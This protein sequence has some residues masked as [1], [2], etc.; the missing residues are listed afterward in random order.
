MSKLLDATLPGPTPPEASRELAVVPLASGDRFANRYD[1]EA[2]VGRGGM[3]TVWRV[4][5]SL[6][7]GE[8]VALK[9]LDHTSEATIE[10]FR[11][12]VLLARRITSPHVARTFDV[13]EHEGRH[14]LTMEYVAGASLGQLLVDHGPL[15]PRRAAELA[16]S[17]ARGLAAAH[18]AGVVHR[19]LKPD[20]VL[21]TDAGRV[22]V[23]DF[24]IARALHGPEAARMTGGVTGTPLYMAPEQLGGAEVD[25]RADLYAL[26]VVL[27]EVLTGEWPFRGDSPIAL[28]VARLREPPRDITA[29]R[30]VP[31]TLAELVMRLLARERDLRP[32]SAA[33]VAVRLDAIAA[34]L[35]TDTRSAPPF[36][37]AA[38]A[39]VTPATISPRSLRLEVPIVVL[40]FEHRGAELDAATTREVSDELIDVLSRTRGLRVLGRGA[41]DRRGDPRVIGGA[42]GARFVIDASVQ[43]G[44]GRLRASVRMTDA[45]SGVQ[46]WSERVEA[47]VAD[48]FEGPGRAALRIAETLRLALEAHSGA[49]RV[50]HDALDRVVQAQRRL[51]GA[52]VRDPDAA[53]SLLDEALELA[54]TFAP[55]LALHA[56]AAV[57]VWFAARPGQPRD[58]RA[59]V[60]RSTERALD[61]AGHLAESHH[62]AAVVAW[63]EGRFRDAALQARTAL[64]IAPSYPDAIAFMG[65]ME[66]E[67][68]R[69]ET[70]LPRLA[71]ALALE[72]GLRIALLE[73]A[74][75]HGLYGDLAEFRRLV[76]YIEKELREDVILGQLLVRVGAWR[77]DAAMVRDG[78]RYLD[79]SPNA[80]AAPLARYGRLMLG[81]GDPDELGDLP[82]WVLSA[83][84]RLASVALQLAAEV[85]GKRGNPEVAV[86]AITRA[87][88]SVLIDI[89]WLDGCP[90]LASIRDRKEIVDARRLVIARCEE[91]WIAS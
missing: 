43:I 19:D 2:L 91:I 17:I 13:G 84:P 74:R 46:V 40:P 22:V 16:A 57:R 79:R 33:E 41:V 20:N 32:A 45:T 68:G 86:A 37:S 64:S 71:L 78:L 36:A 39:G 80:I 60:K 65:Q 24:G 89:A 23:T 26:G 30:P 27:F 44:S 82:D 77:D 7:G 49:E 35:S 73:P 3:G 72:P 1:V 9:V 51:R 31:A 90:M 25:P 55:A 69:S 28:A 87:A 76:S 21:V 67:A 63:H 29:V 61:Q 14:Y 48:P 11:R 88:G 38:A 83:S 53:L 12:E 4:R 42:L 34:A 58:L 75:W 15:G 66:L 5:D 10:R 52:P 81:E 8:L 85:H 50:P 59:L 6:L 54:P 47:D 62:A 18:D 70:G 56:L